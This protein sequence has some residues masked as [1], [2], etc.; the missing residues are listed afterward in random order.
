MMIF[1]CSF[2]LN[3]SP[4]MKNCSF[5]NWFVYLFS[6]SFMGIYFILWVRIHYYHSICCT[7][8]PRFGHWVL[9]QFGFCVFSKCSH[10]FLSSLLSGTA[11]IRHSS[12]T[13]PDLGLQTHLFKRWFGQVI[14]CFTPLNDSQRIKSLLWFQGPFLPFKPQSLPN[15]PPCSLAL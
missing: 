13:F 8:R 2:L 4:V 11:K 10:R 9:F 12:C 1:L 3:Y 15:L 5:I 7:N 14:H 6:H